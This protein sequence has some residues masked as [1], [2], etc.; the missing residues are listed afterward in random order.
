MGQLVSTSNPSIAS[1][2]LAKDSEKI[3]QKSLRSL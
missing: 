2:L 1:L 3:P